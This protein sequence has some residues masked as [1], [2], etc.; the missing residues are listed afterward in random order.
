MVTPGI[1]TA[2]SNLTVVS[3]AIHEEEDGEHQEE[4]KT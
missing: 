4:S 3:E 1:F 2:G